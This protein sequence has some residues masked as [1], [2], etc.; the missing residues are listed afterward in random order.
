MTDFLHPNTVVTPE[1]PVNPSVSQE[2][3]QMGV[4]PDGSIKE[5]SAETQNPSPLPVK[6]QDGEGQRQVSGKDEGVKKQTNAQTE[7]NEQIENLNHAVEQQHDLKKIIRKE[8][9]IFVHYYQSVFLLLVAL[10]IASGY[11][12]LS[13]LILEFKETNQ[14]VEKKLKEREGAQSFLQSIDN[15]ISAAQSIPKE[16]LDRIN[17]SLPNDVQVPMLLKT[18]VEIANKNGVKMVGIQISE[19]SASSELPSYGM[20]QLVPVRI[21]LSIEAPGYLVMKEYLENLQLY[22]RLMDAKSISVTGDSTSGAFSYTLELATYFMQKSEQVTMEDS[23]EAEGVEAP[24]I[25]EEREE[26]F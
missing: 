24:S 1:T 7:S 26:E 12:I 3:K 9:P 4:F 14:R 2:K 15:S 16:T 22:I 6:V 5:G 17:E 13:P 18:F 20:Y 10:F 21:S 11:F 23:L 25:P 19:G 8:S